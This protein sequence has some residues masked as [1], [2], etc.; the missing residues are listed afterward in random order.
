[1]TL[2]RSDGTLKSVTAPLRVGVLLDSLTVPRWIRTVLED[3]RASG[4][5]QLALVVENRATDPVPPGFFRK[6][7]ALRHHLLYALYTRLDTRIFRTAPDA[8]ELC[9]I[10]DL[11]AGLPVVQV[12]PDQTEF[13]DRFPDPAV[14]EILSHRL[15]VALRFGFR[16]LRGRALTIARH[17]V[18]SYHHGDNQVNRGGPAG[19]WEVVEGQPTTGTVLQVLTEDLDNGPVLYRSY[20]MTDRRSVWRNR[21]NVYWKASAF[22]ARKLTDLAR[23]G[24]AALAPPPSANRMLPYSYPL[25]R[26]PHN[27]QMLSVLAR[28]AVRFLGDRAR[29]LFYIGQW[30][31]AYRLGDT[32]AGPHTTMFRFRSITP[33]RDLSWADP[34]P[35]QYQGKH[36][37][38]IEQLRIKDGKGSIAVIALEPDGSHR[39]PVTV[40]ECDYHL[41]SPSVFEYQGQHYMIPETASQRRVELF[42]AVEF[43]WRWE[44]HLVLMEGVNA[45]DPALVE[46]DGRWWMYVTMARDGV[47]Y[48]YD[49]L[50]LFH[51]ASPFGP[52]TPHPLSPIKS[53][54]RSARSAG[55]PFRLDGA[56][57]RPAQNCAKRY[58]RS[59]SFNR[60]L[61]WTVEEYEEE[62]VS[63]ILPRWAPGLICT[64]TFGTCPGLT[65]VDG[66]VRRRRF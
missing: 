50:F 46:H 22:V 62:E 66:L 29:G 24:E 28:I 34:F 56:W 53:D 17:G 32:S 16:I 58:G 3:V 37:I 27:R 10:A 41:S 9:D 30:F 33:P 63:Q 39:P 7:W 15:D 60:V 4:C 57:Y 48:N 18:W 13:S 65:V 21:N 40:L 42:R 1:M 38:F 36:Y 14:D 2:P 5:A 54:A 25:Y 59:L 51:A 47:V 44:H 35:V 43:P 19:F 20:A 55:R 26:I 8:F 61:R 49:E 12:T 31:P 64:H 45:V 6:L 23:R 11:V 52:W